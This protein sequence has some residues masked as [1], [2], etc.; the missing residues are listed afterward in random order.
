MYSEEVSDVFT[1]ASVFD[2]RLKL[3]LA[4]YCL[5]RLYMSTHDLKLKNLS[6][7]M[8]TLSESYDKISKSGSPSKERCETVAENVYDERP[9]ATFNNYDVSVSSN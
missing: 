7:K 5:W 1:V 3:T 8:D 4:G 9:K 2:P 6:F